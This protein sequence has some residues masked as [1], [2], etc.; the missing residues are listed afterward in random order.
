MN[1]L[2]SWAIGHFYDPKE[3]EKWLMQMEAPLSGMDPDKVPESVQAE[4]MSMFY[5]LKRQTSPGG[6]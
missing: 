4:E 2:Y 1:L 3:R 5:E 6:G